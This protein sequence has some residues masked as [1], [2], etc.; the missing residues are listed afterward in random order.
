MKQIGFASGYKY[1]HSLADLS[2]RTISRLKPAIESTIGRPK[3]VLS[4]RSNS[5]CKIYGRIANVH[6]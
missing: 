6:N 1:P 5:V 4:K 3:T 2:I